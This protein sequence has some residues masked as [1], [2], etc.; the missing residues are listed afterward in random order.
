MRRL[1]TMAIVAL[2]A[3]CAPQATQAQKLQWGIKAGVQ[4]N[5]SSMTFDDMKTGYVLGVTA[6]YK[7][8]N[9]PTGWYAAT[10]LLYSEKGFKD[11]W[12]TNVIQSGTIIDGKKIITDMQ[13]NYL[14]LPLHMGYQWKLGKNAKYL[15]EA[16]PYVALGLSGKDM[17]TV[18]SKVQDETTQLWGDNVWTAEASDNVFD[19]KVFNRFDWGLGMTHAVQ[20]SRHWRVALSMDWGLKDT[21]NSGARIQ[22]GKNYSMSASL[23]YNFWAEHNYYNHKNR[24]ENNSSE[25]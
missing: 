1:L 5:A 22:W 10:G 19:D 6:E 24:K 25:W 21:H 23:V 2:T 16:G 12:N 17:R 3:W 18:K 7:F 8:N 11:S 9:R 20:F 13:A 14:I 4:S 15:L